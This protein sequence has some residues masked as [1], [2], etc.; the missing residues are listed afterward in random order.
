MDHL[1]ISMGALRRTASDVEDVRV[2]LGEEWINQMCK[3][4]AGNRKGP[5]KQLLNAIHNQADQAKTSGSRWGNMFR[6]FFLLS[7]NPEGPLP[8]LGGG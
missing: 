4:Q 7:W 8:P 6:R 5:L 2:H 3:A 1:R